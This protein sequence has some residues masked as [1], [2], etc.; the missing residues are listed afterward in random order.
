MEQRRAGPTAPD[1]LL[2]GLPD[3]S[4]NENPQHVAWLWELHPVPLLPLDQVRSGHGDARKPQWRAVTIS[5]ILTK[6]S[7]AFYTQ[8]RRGETLVLAARRTTILVAGEHQQSGRDTCIKHLLEMVTIGVLEDK[9]V[10][11]SR[12]TGTLTFPANFMLVAAPDEPLPLRLPT[13]I[14]SRSAPARR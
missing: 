13:A 8:H 11:I 2:S 9:I 12:A 3:L 5:R 14:R 10:T 6:R 4:S 7:A 1:E